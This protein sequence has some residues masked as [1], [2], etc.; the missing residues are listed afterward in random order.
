MENEKLTLMI[1][2]FAKLTG[3]SKGLAYTLARQNKLPVPVIHLGG[4]RM[5]VSRKAVQALLETNAN[6]KEYLGK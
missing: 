4:K 1:P 5:V 2:E 6:T 3:C